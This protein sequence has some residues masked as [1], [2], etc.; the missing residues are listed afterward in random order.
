M[1]LAGFVV[2]GQ[3]QERKGNRKGN[4]G[5]D[6][7]L[8]TA[9]DQEGNGRA[10]VFGFARR[11]QRQEVSGMARTLRIETAASPSL[12]LQRARR[13]AR[14]NGVLLLGDEN[15][16][17]FSHRMLEGNYRR[18]GPTVIVTITHKHRLVPWSV[19]EGRLRGLFGGGPPRMG[20]VSKKP[21]APT[22]RRTGGRRR[23]TRGPTHHRR[24]PP[25]R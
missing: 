22:A 5:D 23:A 1:R 4:R 16:G 18:L 20:R 7:G 25:R 14:A 17:R 15:S 8:A 21:E 10:L 2:C 19:L 9:R 13:V 24:H 11:A 3:H 12:L 6:Q